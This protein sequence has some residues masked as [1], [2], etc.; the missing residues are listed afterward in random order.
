MELEKPLQ[1]GE[2]K[3][4]VEMFLKFSSPIDMNLYR[5]LEAGQE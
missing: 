1:N 5:Y 2:K 3:K 4:V